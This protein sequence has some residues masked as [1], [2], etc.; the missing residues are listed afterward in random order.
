MRNTTLKTLLVIALSLL[1]LGSFA[2]EAAST[3]APTWE[4][5]GDKVFIV[6]PDGTRVEAEGDICKTS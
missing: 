6:Y 3:D 2:A 4:I 5:E 1:S